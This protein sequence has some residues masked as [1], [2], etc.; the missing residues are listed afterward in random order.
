MSRGNW[1]TDSIYAFTKPSA[2]TDQFTHI[3]KAI[4]HKA[5]GQEPNTG[6]PQVK[7][8]VTDWMQ[9]QN[10]ARGLAKLLDDNYLNQEPL[11]VGVLGVRNA[12]SGKVDVPAWI[13][14][15][16]GFPALLFSDCRESSGR[17]LHH[18]APGA[19]FQDCPGRPF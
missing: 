15:G 16:G 17:A 11:A 8:I 14:E 4:G 5:H 6:L 18:R 9:N 12:F 1:K 13:S 19:R 10:E 3:E 7:V 2:F